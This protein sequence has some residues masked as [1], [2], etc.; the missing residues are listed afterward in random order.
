MRLAPPCVAALAAL[1]LSAPDLAG[2]SPWTLPAGDAA[3]VGTFDFEVADEEYL[4]DGG[5]R[6][7]PLEGRYRA[8]TYTAAAR[9]GLTDRFE[10]EI[11]LPVKQVTYTSDPVVLLPAPDGTASPFDYYQENVIDLSR[12]VTG[13]GDL[14]ISARYQLFRGPVVGAFELGLKSP[15]GYAPPAGTFGD[16]PASREAFLADVGRFVAPENVQDDVTLGEGQ[17]D[18]VPGFLLGW[19]GRHGTFVRLDTGF[20]VRLGGAGDELRGGLKVGQLV[21]GALVLYAGVDAEYAVTDGKVIGISV[22]AQDPELPAVEYGGVNNLDLREVR[23]EHDRVRLAPGAIIRVAPGVE[24]NLAYS[25]TLF[26][27]NTA[28]IQG[29]SVGVGMRTRLAE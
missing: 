6:P 4:D 16:R 11:A 9:F 21:G 17:F 25:R 24:I 12:S 19:A 13:L 26:G 5:A 7:F 20:A 15:T 28:A 10:L 23:L 29:F 14:R 22:A 8:T 1:A 27:R 18:V 3:F 2:A